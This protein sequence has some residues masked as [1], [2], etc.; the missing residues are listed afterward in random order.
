MCLDY[1]EKISYSQAVER[2]HNVPYH[3]CNGTIETKVKH[4]CFNV[5][6]LIFGLKEKVD[7]DTMK[8]EYSVQLFTVVKDRVCGPR[9]RRQGRPASREGERGGER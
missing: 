9:R 2:C 6:E 1:V 3:K 4:A 5:N 8:E 7:F